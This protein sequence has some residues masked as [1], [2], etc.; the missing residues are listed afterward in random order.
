VRNV[1]KIDFT[2][3]V[4]IVTGAGGGLGRDYALQLAA[5]G[6]AV[7]V[8]DLGGTTTGAGQDRAPA[9]AVVRAIVVCGGRAIANYD[10]VA[11]RAGAEA[12]IAAALAHFGRIDILIN[13]AGNQR[14]GR[15]EQLSDEE[16]DAVL[17]VHLRGAFYVSQLAYRQMVQQRYGRLIFTSSASGLFGNYIRANYAA[18]KAGLVGLMHSFALEGAYAGVLANALLPTAASRLG[19]AP[20]QAIRPEWEAF[21]P[22]N[23]NGIERIGAKIR[24]EYVTPLVLYLA[25]EA[26]TSSHGIW[27]ATGG[28]YAR[29][30]V[31]VTRGWLGPADRPATAEEI[32]AH[33]AQIEDRGGFTEPHTVAEELAEVARH[34]LGRAG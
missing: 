17:A 5:R 15:I 23:V 16:F 6:A 34:T 20:A 1:S 14:N 29:V 31:G 27:S 4:A 30:F 19:Q 33:L 13:N 22:Q 21:Q 11:T 26:C 10:S 24:V 2:G 28:R 7:V 3:R 32:E 25:S 12:I 8:N 18:A 9:D